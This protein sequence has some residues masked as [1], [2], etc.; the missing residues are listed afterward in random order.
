MRTERQ[1]I[2]STVVSSKTS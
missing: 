1:N 2:V